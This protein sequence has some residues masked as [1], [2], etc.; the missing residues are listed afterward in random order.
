MFAK[1]YLLVL[2]KNDINHLDW[3]QNNAGHWI[4][5]FYGFGIVDVKKSIKNAKKWKNL[6]H[7]IIIEESNNSI[8]SIED[9]KTLISQIK[10]TKA[11]SIEFIDIIV[12]IDHTSIGDLEIILISPYG[13]KSILSQEHYEIFQNAFT[14]KNWSF[15]SMRHLD[16]DSKGTWKLQVFDKREENIGLLKDWKLKIYGHN[17]QINL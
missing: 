13:T 17:H 8:I 4:N 2:K 16:E 10:V 15:G 7:E 9:N 3:H 6:P 11:I 1:F 12:N 5:H 14:Y